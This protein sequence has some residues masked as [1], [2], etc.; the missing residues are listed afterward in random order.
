MSYIPPKDQN[1]RSDMGV[2]VTISPDDNG[3]TKV[4]LDDISW[5]PR[6][7]ASHAWEHHGLFTFESFNTA[8]LQDLVTDREKLA[9]LGE[10]ILIRLLVLNKRMSE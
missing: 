4:I 2:A 10:N 1:V 7:G 6:V 9:L 3:Q 5:L 8:D